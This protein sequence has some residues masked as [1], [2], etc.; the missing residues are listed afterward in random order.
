M[1]GGNR[2]KVCTSSP[3]RAAPAANVSPA[4]SPPSPVL[5]PIIQTTSRAMRP[6][7]SGEP[8]P[9]VP[10]RCLASSALRSSRDLVSFAEVGGLDAGVGQQLSGR[11]PEDDPA[12]FHHAHAIRDRH[13]RLDVLLDEHHGHA[14]IAS[15]TLERLDD[16]AD[17]E[18]SETE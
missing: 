16:L 12:T 11:P 13:R 9:P 4:E 5:P 6:H 2:R 8:P 17:D 10:V 18:R 14:F 3:D 1:M 7:P 15:E